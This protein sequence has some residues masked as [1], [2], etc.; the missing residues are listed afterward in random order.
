M[1]RVALAAMVLAGCFRP[2]EH[3]CALDDDCGGGTCV[4]ATG[5]C[6]FIDDT[7]C[8]GSLRYGGGAGGLANACVFDEPCADAA[9]IDDAAVDARLL[10]AAV[11]D[12]PAP[13]FSVAHLAAAD[14]QLGAADWVI[15]GDVTIDTSGAGGGTALPTGVGLTVAPQQP[16]G[17]ELMVLHVRALTIAP[18]KRLRVIGARPLVIV[19]TTATL[20][21]VIDVGAVR[22]TPGAGGAGTMAGAGAGGLGG[23]SA[24]YEAGGGGA[25]FGTAGA[26]GG[27]STGAGPAVG[28]DPGPAYGAATLAELRGGSGGGNGATGSGCSGAPGLGGAGGGAVQVSTVGAIT[29]GVAGGINAG[30]GGGGAGRLCAG[31]SEPGRGGGSGGA[32]YLQGASIDVRGVIAANGGGGGGASFTLTMQAGAAGADG[33]LATT[34]ALG[35]MMGTSAS[36]GDGGALNLA[37]TVGRATSSSDGGGGGGAVGRI[38][39]RGVSTIA[40]DISPAPI[41]VPP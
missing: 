3:R 10:D 34:P 16:A 36:G 39:L 26:R 24:P 18:G 11:P 27:T 40:G 17:G 20:D 41:T 7:C 6:A 33:D 28:G 21:G 38:V 35:G 32:I 22:G 29:I 19:A 9:V 5:Y 2:D 13:P 25:G 8:V 12:A 15:T 1:W 14:A 30:G 23:A 37:P 4:I 31:N